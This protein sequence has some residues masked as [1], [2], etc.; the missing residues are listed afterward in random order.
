MSVLAMAVL[1]LMMGLT[2]VDVLGRYIFNRPVDGTFEMTEMMLAVLVFCSLAFC[3]FS[4]GHISVD[5]LVKNFSKG[6]QKSIQVVN[7]ILTIAIMGLV[8]WMTFQ[9]ALDI[10]ATKD[11]TMILQIPI[12]PFMLIASL[13][14][15]GMTF[16]VLV[17][18][19]TLLGKEDK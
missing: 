4:S 19:L 10:K 9:H 1:C 7:Y 3:Q 16:Q 11:V 5:I 15:L 2:A 13:G 17:D 18:L 8:A 14:A 12:Y 6:V